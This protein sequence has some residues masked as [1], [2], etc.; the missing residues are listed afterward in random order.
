MCTI[1]L[2]IIIRKSSPALLRTGK[3]I[4]NVWQRVMWIVLLLIRREHLH[5]IT[6]SFPV[7]EKVLDSSISVKI[8]ILVAKSFSIT[9]KSC[10]LKGLLQLKCLRTYPLEILQYSEVQIMFV[11]FCEC[12]TTHH[13]LKPP[14][15][16]LTCRTTLTQNVYTTC[17]NLTPFSVCYYYLKRPTPQKKKKTKKNQIFFYNYK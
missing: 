15:D 8:L 16:A 12:R 11:L 5:C 2:Q 1:L 17:L 14:N 9:S 4:R 6:L 13:L 7:M 3:M 10:S